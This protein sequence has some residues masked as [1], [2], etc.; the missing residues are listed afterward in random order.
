MGRRG[1]TPEKSGYASVLSFVALWT[2]AA[3]ILGPSEAL[4]CRS[5]W[6]RRLP[7]T[8]QDRFVVHGML[9]MGLDE[10]EILLVRTGAMALK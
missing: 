2:S 5:R 6:A 7:R 1:L 3:R 8:M 10:S 4:S 9:E